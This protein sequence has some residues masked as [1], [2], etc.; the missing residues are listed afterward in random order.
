MP[1][2]GRRHAGLRVPA[3]SALA[4]SAAA[5]SASLRFGRAL[6]REI[7][8]EI[9]RRLDECQHPGKLGI[10]EV[11]GG[12]ARTVDVDEVVL[13]PRMLD[14]PADAQRLQRAADGR[15]VGV[16]E[17]QHER[18]R[19]VARQ[20]RREPEDHLE[21]QRRLAVLGELEQHRRP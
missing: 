13:A 3:S 10:R 14:Q 21:G 16:G 15:A 18:N 9:E 19:V 20:D 8:R 17:V 5:T 2:G 7:E 11:P 12:V 1:A 4:A 6:G